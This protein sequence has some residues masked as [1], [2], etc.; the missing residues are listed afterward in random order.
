VNTLLDE[1]FSITLCDANG[2]KQ[3]NLNNFIKKIIFYTL[4]FFL[5]VAMVIVGSIF[6][7]KHAVDK[8]ERKKSELS[9]AY[10]ELDIKN[11]ELQK[12]VGV[13]QQELKTKRK[14]LLEVADSLMDIE[15][16]IGISE[17]N[18]EDDL[19]LLD[20]VSIAKMTSEQRATMLQFI[21][22]GYPVEF[23]G[24]TSTFGYR[25]HPTLGKKELHRGVDFKAPLN[26]PVFATADG[27]VEYGGFHE[28]SGYG[29]LIILTHSFG[30][31]TYYCHLNKVLVKYGT[32][33]KKGDLIG[34]SGNTGLSSGPHLHYEIRYFTQALN[35]NQFIHWGMTNYDD[36]FEKEKN[37]PWQSL[38]KATNHIKVIKPSQTPQ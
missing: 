3:F 33:I 12:S 8:A 27:M 36:I 37:I 18:I 32:F 2:V 28:K 35:P 6:Y 4:I 16:M 13:I 10:S 20:R 1:H 30:F 25:T 7:L 5:L 19:T 14:E 9:L 29:N 34:Y 38:I 21:P 24:I 22:S 17:G 26:T 11:K 23:N 15:Q 31:K